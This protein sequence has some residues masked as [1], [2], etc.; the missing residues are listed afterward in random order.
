MKQVLVANEKQGKTKD[1]LNYQ[2]YIFRK[3]LIPAI[4]ILK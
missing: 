3:L 1:L 4:L 2:L